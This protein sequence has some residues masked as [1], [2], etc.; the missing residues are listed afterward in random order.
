MKRCVTFAGPGRVVDESRGDGMVEV[1]LDWKLAQGQSATAYFTR[2]TITP[3]EI[4][5]GIDSLRRLCA[6]DGPSWQGDEAMGPEIA[7]ALVKLIEHKHNDLELKEM[8]ERKLTIMPDPTKPGTARNMIS[9]QVEGMKRTLTCEAM[10]FIA[11]RIMRS[12]HTAA[13]S[14]ELLER[15][16]KHSKL[17]LDWN[18]S[19]T[20][21]TPRAEWGS[22]RQLQRV[23][24]GERAA[25]QLFLS[26]WIVLQRTVAV[27]NAKARA[28]GE[29]D[30]PRTMDREQLKVLTEIF[31]SVDRRADDL[32]DCAALTRAIFESTGESVAMS[33]TRRSSRSA[34]S[35]ALTAVSQDGRAMGMEFISAVQLFQKKQGWEKPQLRDEL[36]RWR[37]RISEQPTYRCV[38]ENLGFKSTVD[39]VLDQLAAEHKLGLAKF[40]RRDWVGAGLCFE[41]VRRQIAMSANALFQQDKAAGL[42]A[43]R[44]P[45]VR[46]FFLRVGDQANATNDKLVC[47]YLRSAWVA[48]LVAA[49]RKGNPQHRDAFQRANAAFQLGDKAKAEEH[50]ATARDALTGAEAAQTKA[51]EAAKKGSPKAKGETKQLELIQTWI[52]V[53][54]RFERHMAAY[55]SPWINDFVAV[56]A[57]GP[58]FVPTDADCRWATRDA[59]P[60]AEAARAE[61]GIIGP[62]TLRAALAKAEDARPFAGDAM[63]ALVDLKSLGNDATTRYSASRMTWLTTAQHLFEPARMQSMYVRWSNSKAKGISYEASSRMRKRLLQVRKRSALFLP[64]HTRANSISK[65]SCL[66]RLSPSLSLLPSALAM[67]A[68]NEIS[69]IRT[70]RPY[71]LSVC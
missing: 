60:V 68:T 46:E 21:Y 19:A 47:C 15:H 30:D 63:R 36:L 61:N 70:P 6:M 51:V 69:V 13:G 39:A 18:P 65:L 9:F 23:V 3:L 50:L 41:R 44:Y 64:H 58:N 11:L 66:A 35:A 24:V 8:L 52:Q 32:A 48:T 12:V 17:S 56:A 40:N 45:L 5:F 27:K 4:G 28:A 71:L 7:E 16:A 25:L 62:A 54:K 29:V 31:R 43:G 2:E 1:A 10:L 67:S 33:P 55:S 14:A 53:V 34:F 57:G 42:G 26:Q 22:L 59:E 38:W 49:P 20:L 37:A